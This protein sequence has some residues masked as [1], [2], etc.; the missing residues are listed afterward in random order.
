MMW[1]SFRLCGIEK[2]ASTV[3][4]YYSPVP[5]NPRESPANFDNLQ[6]AENRV[7]LPQLRPPTNREGLAASLSNPGL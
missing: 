1:L 4:D 5:S 3:P 7:G 6:G 2:R